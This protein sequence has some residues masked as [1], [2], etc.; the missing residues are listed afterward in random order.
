MPAQGRRSV[1][2]PKEPTTQPLAPLGD[3]ANVGDEIDL[4]LSL[5]DSADEIE[6]QRAILDVVHYATR[7]TRQVQQATEMKALSWRPIVLAAAA[8]FTML[9]TAYL[10]LAQQDWVFG[11]T[12]AAMSPARREASLRWAM[13]LAGARANEYRLNRGVM[14]A[15]L[16]DVGED[17]TGIA[18]TTPDPGSFDL[19][20]KNPDP[21]GAP[22]ILRSGDDPRAFLALSRIYL[23]ERP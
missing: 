18:Y 5:D 14:P 1:S 12:A 16:R 17:W 20:A 13:F 3:I 11:P 8:V 10:F 19:R 9:F 2:R 4:K 21:T 23:R 7:L 22:L 6:K 15:S